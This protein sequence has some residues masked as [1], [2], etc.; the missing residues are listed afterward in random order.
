MVRSFKQLDRIRRDTDYLSV[1]SS[2]A[3]KY[4]PEKLRIPTL[5]TQ[6]LPTVFKTTKEDMP[7]SVNLLL[8]INLLN[9]G[10]RSHINLTC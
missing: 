8:M 6:C 2:N 10:G 9:W 5:F 3:G 7:V 1:F 4:G